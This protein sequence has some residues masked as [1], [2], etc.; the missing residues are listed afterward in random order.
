M[1]G[2][3][4]PRAAVLP[5]GR[6]GSPGAQTPCPKGLASFSPPSWPPRETAHA[7][8]SQ[9]GSGENEALNLQTEEKK[10]L[11]C[12][13][14]FCSLSPEFENVEFSQALPREARAVPHTDPSPQN[15]PCVTERVCRGG[16]GGGTGTQ[17]REVQGLFQERRR[18][19][20]HPESR[21]RALGERTGRDTA[22]RQARGQMAA[23][24]N[25]EPKTELGRL[26]Q[27]PLQ[28]LRDD[29]YFPHT[30]WSPGEGASRLR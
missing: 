25:R 20:R 28:D 23:P 6:G 13:L 27:L 9:V 16:W 26:L 8:P 15:G 22:R 29:P 18:V 12:F 30:L 10:E 2:R 5:R 1:R 14:S 17:I 24:T 11:T 7:S 21:R 4:S 3:Y 19:D